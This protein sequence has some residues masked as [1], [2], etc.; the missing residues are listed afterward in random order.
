VT[1]LYLDRDSPLHRLHPT[2]KLLGMILFSLA[3]LLRDDPRYLAW[4][5]GAALLLM[6]VGRAIAHL[7]RLWFILPTFLIVGLILWL[8][9]YP[10]TTPLVR[11]GGWTIH[12]EPVV[13]ALAVACRTSIFFILGL[14]F[15]AC[16]PVEE[17]SFA[18]RSLGLPAPAT[19]AL[20][21]AFRLMPLYLGSA[22][23]VLQAQ[24]LRGLEPER[25]GLLE[26]ARRMVPLLVP[27]T[28]SALRGIDLMAMALESRGFGARRQRSEALAYPWRVADTAAV[29]LPSLLILG[30]ILSLWSR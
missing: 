20:T 8:I 15:L 17:F 21:L 3:V 6:A 19:V 12:Q 2:A 28:L 4:L 18:L 14:T 13:R 7:R 29:A 9:L 5:L 25:G 27:T 30:L 16:I 10:G 24:K 1:R 26:R 22:T 23:M 11:L